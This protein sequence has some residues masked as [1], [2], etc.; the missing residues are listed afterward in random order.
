M[1]FHLLAM[2]LAQMGRQ[3]DS[4]L[5]ELVQMDRQSDSQIGWQSDSTVRG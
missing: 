5:M 2:A 4:A 3:S 1:G